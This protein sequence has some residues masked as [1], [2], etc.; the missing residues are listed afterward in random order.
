MTRGKGRKG[1]EN[2]GEKNFQAVSARDKNERAG[3]RAVPGSLGVPV[4]SRFG[5]LGCAGLRGF[6]TSDLYRTRVICVIQ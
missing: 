5:L 6:D 1:E 2:E 4:G 3:E